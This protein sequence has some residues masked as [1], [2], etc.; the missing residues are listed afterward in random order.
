MKDFVFTI[1]PINTQQIEAEFKEVFQERY[2]GH[3]TGGGLIRFHIQ[4][5]LDDLDSQIVEAL[6]EAHVPGESDD[7]VR[8]K[9]EQ[10]VKDAIAIVRSFDRTALKDSRKPVDDLADVLEA[11]CRILTGA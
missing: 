1:K 5:P 11:V 6:F 3:S 2:I 7:T 9:A 8:D 4:E 10:K